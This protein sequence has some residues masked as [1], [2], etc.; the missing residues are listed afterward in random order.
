MYEFYSSERSAVKYYLLK[1]FAAITYLVE[2][3]NDSS[4]QTDFFNNSNVKLISH[5]IHFVI[6]SKIKILNKDFIFSIKNIFCY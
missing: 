5:K 1:S 4:K 3:A 2:F 6:M